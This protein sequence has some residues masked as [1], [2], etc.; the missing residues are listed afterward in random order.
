MPM[1]SLCSFVRLG[2]A[3]A[4]TLHTQHLLPYQLRE[5]V[6]L[7]CFFAQRFPAHSPL[8]LYRYDFYDEF[9]GTLVLDKSTAEI[10][11]MF[12]ILHHLTKH[13]QF[14]YLQ[15]TMERIMH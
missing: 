10:E 6:C 13:Q 11:E 8:R 9:L 15:E 7:R 1:P 3:R 14:E 5:L 12:L 2:A 4:Y